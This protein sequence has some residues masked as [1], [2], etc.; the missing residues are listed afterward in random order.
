M[1]LINEQFFI[2]LI[3]T[4]HIKKCQ[5]EDIALIAEFYDDII[6]YLD[7][8]INYPR[9]IYKVYPSED[10]VKAM[11][12][13]E[14]Q[15]ICILNGKIIGA[16]VLNAEPQGSYWKANWSQELEDGSYMVL[17][18]L[19]IDHTMQ[20]QG[21]ASDIIEFCIDKAKS[22]GYKAIRLDVIPDNYPAK[23]L[24]EKNGFEYVGDVDLELEIGNNPLF[25]LYEL[26]F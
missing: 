18:T 7:N 2:I 25:S 16:F 9:W 11:V 5:K 4:M 17:Q 3:D 24:F 13:K 12:E 6:E 1:I 23:K 15:Y 21:L 26:N 10:S 8:H 22:N 19:A 14:S 20:R